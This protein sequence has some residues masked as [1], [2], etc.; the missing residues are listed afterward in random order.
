MTDLSIIIPAKN[1]EKR[2][3]STLIAYLDFFKKLKIDFEILVVINNS[4]DKTE[5]VVKELKN[6]YK[7]INYVI[8]KERIGKGGALIEGFKIVKGNLITYTDADGATSPETL[9]EL[10]QKINGYDGIIGSRWVKGAK[11]LKKQTLKRRIA[12]RGFN[13]LTRSIL[14]LNYKDTQC[15]AKIFKKYVI[16]AIKNEVEPTDFAIDAVL[17]YHM[18]EKGFK[19]KEEPITWEDKPFSTLKMSKVIPNMFS[20]IIKVRL[21]K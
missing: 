5:E 18:K 16:D 14:G 12:S 1:E 17:L 2:I 3:P 9:N 20:T 6:K 11:I 21:K 8:F 15:A 13:L 4:N 7:E 10:I 19:I